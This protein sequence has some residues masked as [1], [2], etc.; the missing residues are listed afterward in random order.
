MRARRQAYEGLASMLDAGI[1]VRTALDRVA[2]DRK[3]AFGEVLRHLREEVGRGRPLA[4]A[5]AERPGAFPRHHVEL[6]R[7]GE[8]AGTIDRTLRALA[9]EEAAAE[10]DL[11]K[12]AAR[13]AYPL[14]VVHFAAVPASIAGG[15]AGSLAG[16]LLGCLQYWVPLWVLLGAVA[17]LFRRA[18]TG[19]AA[20][21]FLLAVPLLGGVLRDGAHARWARV[22]A[23]LDDA[24][25]PADACA[26]RAAAATG[27]ATLE[28][29]LAAPAEKIRRG[30][31]RADAFAGAGLPFEIFQALAH[32]E[33]SG[34]VASSLTRAAE[35]RERSLE[36]RT[37]TLLN[38]LPAFATI[39]AGAVVLWVAVGFYAGLFRVP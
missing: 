17:L 14:F 36:T 6:V 37:A 2:A 33:V 15:H 10:R 30:S 8:T 7:A 26:E 5:M 16:F 12:V 23:A 24:G 32:G 11:G 20:A 22:Y 3:G 34:T 9:G 19:G 31:S 28:A 21:R 4:D 38:L 13:L 29:A 35:A 1:P 18:R 39:L 27:Y 25:L